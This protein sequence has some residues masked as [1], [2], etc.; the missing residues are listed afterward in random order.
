MG[1]KD[2]VLEPSIVNFVVLL[3][4]LFNHFFIKSLLGAK[5]SAGCCENHEDR[6][7]CPALSPISCHESVIFLYMVCLM[8]L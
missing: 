3:W 8:H 2:L 5:P 4:S 7:P 6:I 1:G